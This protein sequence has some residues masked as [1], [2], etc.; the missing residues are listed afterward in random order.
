MIANEK[1]NEHIHYSL[2]RTIEIALMHD[3]KRQANFT[4]NHNF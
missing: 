1:V 3:D 4:T 2:T